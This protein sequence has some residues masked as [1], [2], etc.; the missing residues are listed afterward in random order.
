MKIKMIT[1]ILN[2]LSAASD[3]FKNQIIRFQKEEEAYNK[4]RILFA[5]IDECKKALKY[6]K[7]SKWSPKQIEEFVH[8]TGQ[9]PSEELKDIPNE[10]LQ[11]L[12][13]VVNFDSKSV[14]NM[15]R[16]LKMLFP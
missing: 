5:S 3:A 8:F 13:L 15:K 16:T 11:T 6:C 12:N 7:S 4:L 14:E 2:Y 10:T 9:I 1:S